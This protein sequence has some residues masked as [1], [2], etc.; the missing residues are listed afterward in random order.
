MS[1]PSERLSASLASAMAGAGWR[2]R[3][4]DTAS[5]R[6]APSRVGSTL[7]ALR[8]QPSAFLGSR[9][10]SEQ[11]AETGHHADPSGLDA[12][13]L[14][15]G[16]LR[17][18][19]EAAGLRGVSVDLVA[20]RVIGVGLGELP[21]ALEGRRPIAFPEQLDHG[22][23]GRR[24]RGG[25]GNGRHVEAAVG[26][27]ARGRPGG[28]E[29]EQRDERKGW[30]TDPAYQTGGKAGE[31]PARGA[32]ASG[33]RGVLAR[34]RGSGGARRP[35]TGRGPARAATPAPAR[36]ASRP[37]RRRTRLPRSRTRLKGSL[38]PGAIRLR[39]LRHVETDEARVRR[40]ERENFS[41]VVR[42]GPCR[43]GGRMFRARGVESDSIGRAEEV[44]PPDAARLLV[45]QRE[46]AD[47][48]DRAHVV[49]DAGAGR[50][51][52]LLNHS[53]MVA[54]RGGGSEWRRRGYGS[55]SSR[56]TRRSPSR[57]L[58][59]PA[60]QPLLVQRVVERSRSPA[61]RC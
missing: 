32:R 41:R 43:I 3:S 53:V 14:Q 22:V 2:W 49:G 17:L 34:R 29:E 55:G 47:R 44:E 57:R 56:G 59:Y 4:S 24:R 52:W 45:P 10:S 36:V 1:L 20:E 23:Q 8:N 18:S 39:A 16:L 54:G 11:P 33:A 30:V 60:D 5:P 40:G 7:S 13:R 6:R 19:G 12:E 9:A 37:R 27:G 48:H 58:M 38:R 61:R 25:L 42:P 26:D 35:R 21:R 50:A 46:A 15:V 28:K 31:A 51:H